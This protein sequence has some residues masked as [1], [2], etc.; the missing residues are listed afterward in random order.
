M[1]SKKMLSIVLASLASLNSLASAT[2]KVEDVEAPSNIVEDVKAPSNIKKGEQMPI[3]SRF[4]KKAKKRSATKMNPGEIIP[5]LKS[6]D[7]VGNFKNVKGRPAN[8]NIVPAGRKGISNLA[9]TYGFPLALGTGALLG[10]GV[11]LKNKLSKN[12][13]KAKQSLENE[14]E[15]SSVSTEASDENLE[16][17]F[18]SGVQMVQQEDNQIPTEDNQISTNEVV[19]PESMDVEGAS[20]VQD[21]GKNNEVPGNLPNFSAPMDQENYQA[22]QVKKE[23][24]PVFN[25]PIVKENSN[26]QVEEEE[27]THVNKQPKVEINNEASVVQKKLVGK[28]AEKEK[29]KVLKS[30]EDNVSLVFYE[31]NNKN[32]VAKWFPIL[33]QKISKGKYSCGALVRLIKSNYNG[34]LEW[35]DFPVLFDVN[36]E[37]HGKINIYFQ[38]ISSSLHENFGYNAVLFDDFKHPDF[39]KCKTK[40]TTGDIGIFQDAVEYKLNKLFEEHGLEY[41]SSIL[42]ERLKKFGFGI[43]T[44][45]TTQMWLWRD[46][47]VPLFYNPSGYKK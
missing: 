42:Q 26:P 30:I 40:L 6:A 31:Y 35:E 18:D 44:K 36:A 28:E 13:K 38:K 1:D 5:E 47:R 14:E 17:S 16:N 4:S 19:P 8:A 33:E 37:E 45:Y 29:T 3:N 11:A 12:S 10:G 39:E 22:P 23:D 43:A 46:S 9:T 7:L 20:D 21:D 41:D 34:E 15:N 32:K 24:L 25:E 27:V 2:P